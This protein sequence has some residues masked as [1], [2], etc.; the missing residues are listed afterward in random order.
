ML[1]FTW[2]ERLLTLTVWAGLILGS[3]LCWTA[4]VWAGGWLVGSW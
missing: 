2:R 3:L 4:I 1:R